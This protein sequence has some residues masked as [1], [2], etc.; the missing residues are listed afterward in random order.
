MGSVMLQG[1]PSDLLSIS[2]QHL[3][4]LTEDQLYELASKLCAR[5]GLMQKILPDYHRCFANYA[6]MVRPLF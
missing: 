2:W 1:V 6:E 5:L 4:F 3:G